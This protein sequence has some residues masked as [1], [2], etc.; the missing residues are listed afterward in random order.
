[1]KNFEHV[2]VKDHTVRFCVALSLGV[3][4][5]GCGS[6]DSNSNSLAASAAKYVGEFEAPCEQ[7]DEIYLTSDGEF[8]YLK[9]VYTF[10]QRDSGSPVLNYWKDYTVH[11]PTDTNCTMPAIDTLT[12]WGENTLTLVEIVTMQGQ[13]V[14]KVDVD[15]GPYNPNLSIGG[16]ISLNGLTIPGA[17]FSDTFTGMDLISIEGNDLYWGDLTAATDAEGY[18]GALGPVPAMTRI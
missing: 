11:A 5:A 7:S 14:A 17:F 10:E 1:M 2:S 18:P 16:A 15:D 8:V 13:E 4:L 9:P 3:L 6:S 12:D